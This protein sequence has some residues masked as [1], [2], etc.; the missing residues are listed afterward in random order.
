MVSLMMWEWPCVVIVLQFTCFPS[1][2]FA[3]TIVRL[4][5]VHVGRGWS[6]QV[7][8]ITSPYQSPNYGM[9]HVVMQ[10]SQHA[11]KPWMASMSSQ[12]HNFEICDCVM[13]FLHYFNVQNQLLWGLS[14]S[15]PSSAYPNNHVQWIG[16]TLQFLARNIVNIMIICKTKKKKIKEPKKNSPMA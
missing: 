7:H 6:P 11:S 9:A 4:L 13:Y 5:Y 2:T 8:Q 1:I 16:N 12:Y 14:M 15:Y 10:N 3:Y